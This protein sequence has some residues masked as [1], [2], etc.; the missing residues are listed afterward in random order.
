MCR[1]SVELMPSS[2]SVPKRSGE[3]AIAPLPAG[4]SGGDGRPHRRQ[5]RSR[6]FRRRPWPRRTRVGQKTGGAVA[7]G[8]S[9]GTSPGS[10]TGSIT[11][12]GAYAQR[13]R[14]RRCPRPNAKTASALSSTRHPGRCRGLSG[15]RYRTRPEWPRGDGN[16]GGL[17]GCRLGSPE[18]EPARGRRSSRCVGSA[19]HLGGADEAFQRR[20]HLAWWKRPQT[21][22]GPSARLPM[23]RPLRWLQAIAA[24]HDDGLI[25][26]LG[27]DTVRQ[28]PPSTR[29]EHHEH[30]GGGIREEERHLAGAAASSRPGWDLA[31]MRS[32]ARKGGRGRRPGESLAAISTI[33]TSSVQDAEGLQEPLAAAT[34]RPAVR[35]GGAPARSRRRQWNMPTLTPRPSAA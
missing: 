16:G 33:E 13:G 5:G 15:R 21:A 10:G 22:V 8:R 9:S 35:P 27:R 30:P 24:G 18:V 34:E 20:S 1:A 14:R 7:G 29:P 31:L 6:A 12:R 32:S 23:W 26:H 19:A 4:S 11:A 25:D 2:I 17:R 28:M 3:A